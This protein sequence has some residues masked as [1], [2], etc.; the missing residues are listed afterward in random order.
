MFSIEEHSLIILAQGL[1]SQQF[2]VDEESLIL[3]KHQCNVRKM[4]K[5]L[6]NRKY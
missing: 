4:S 2:R 5:K 6:A 3:L 1:F